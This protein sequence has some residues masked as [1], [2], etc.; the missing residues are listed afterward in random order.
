MVDQSRFDV[1]LGYFNINVQDDDASRVLRTVFCDYQLVV[2]D[3]IIF[4]DS[5]I[6]HIH[7]HHIVL[8]GKIFYSLVKNI[9]F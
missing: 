1:I 4:N 8:N 6:I 9:Y 2:N 5:I 3:S 7:L